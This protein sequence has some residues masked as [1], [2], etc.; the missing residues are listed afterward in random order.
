MAK[1]ILMPLL[2]PSMT[3]GTLVKWLKKEG[4]AVKSGEVIAEVETDKATMDLEAFDSGILRKILVQEG[5][6]VPVQSRIGLIGTKDEKIDDAAPAA[7]APSAPAVE[8]KGAPAPEPKASEAAKPAPT[9]TAPAPVAVPSSGRVKAS[10]LAKKIAADKGVA[11]ASLTG[12]GPNGRIVK[13]DVLN[14]PANGH[15]PGAGRSIFGAGPVAKEG[16]TKLSTMRSVIAKRLLESKTTIP[17]FYLEIEVDAKP[18]MEL[19]AQLNETLGK[20]TPPVKLSLNDLVLKAAAEA[21][22]RVPA[23]NASFE[24]DSI[25]QFPDVQLSFAVAI[26]EGLITPIIKEAQNK[27][28]IQISA[29][30]KSLAGKAKEG[31]LKPDE[32]QGGTFT[33]S[34]LGMLGIDSFCAIINPPQAAILAVGNIVKKPVV[35]ANDNIVVGL[36]Q[37]F[38]LSCDHRVVDGAVGAAYLKELRELIEKPA[39]LLL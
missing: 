27:S 9:A 7:P 13:N 29:E 38:T 28:L 3:E 31:K 11:L 33:V 36:R 8:A 24:G 17:H 23:V 37:S 5:T 15:A 21:V 32:F 16:S 2:S 18:M 20:L 34:N 1:D 25:R 14:A 26:A 39:L 35:D 30:A 22:R 6:K 10:P 4:D 12:S 19:R